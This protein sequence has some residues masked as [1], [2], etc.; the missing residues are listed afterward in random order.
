[1]ICLRISYWPS[2]GLRIVTQFKADGTFVREHGGPIRSGE[3]ADT[4]P[5]RYTGIR[6]I[7]TITLTIRLTDTN[8]VVNTFI[9]KQGEAGRVVKCL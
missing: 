6:R 8:E 1:L 7:D 4:H 3:P 5:A 9:L 2:S